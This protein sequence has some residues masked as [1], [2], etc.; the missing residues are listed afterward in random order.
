M[1]SLGKAIPNGPRVDYFIRKWQPMLKLT[2]D[3]NQREEERRTEWRKTEAKKNEQM[4]KTCTRA[5]FISYHHIHRQRTKN[6][7]L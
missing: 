4:C 7:N 6:A 2:A 3:I 1:R 5:V